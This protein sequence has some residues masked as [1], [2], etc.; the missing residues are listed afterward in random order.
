VNQ[1]KKL[2]V[3]RFQIKKTENSEKNLKL[4]IFV[5]DRFVIVSFNPFMHELSFNS[6][7]LNIFAEYN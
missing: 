2:G 7:F 6:K 5:S 1:N 3:K 4:S